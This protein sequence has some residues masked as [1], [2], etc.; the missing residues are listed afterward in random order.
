MYRGKSQLGHREY[1]PRTFQV[2]TTTVTTE[3]ENTLPNGPPVESGGPFKQQISQGPC[4]L[5]LARVGVP[6]VAQV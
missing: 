3:N 1:G 6:K 4:T 2:F 5:L